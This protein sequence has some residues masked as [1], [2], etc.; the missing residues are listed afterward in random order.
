MLAFL[1]TA[2]AF[3]L[4]AS[5]LVRASEIDARTKVTTLPQCG[6]L[7]LSWTPGSAPYTVTITDVTSGI[8]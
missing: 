6:N 1:F 8:S 3:L 4:A 7:T 2:F 5:N